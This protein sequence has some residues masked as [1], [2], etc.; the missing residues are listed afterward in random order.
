MPRHFKDLVAYLTDGQ[1]DRLMGAA[2]QLIRKS[3]EF[4]RLMRD[5]EEQSLSQNNLKRARSAHSSITSAVR[6]LL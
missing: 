4:Q 5:I 2:T 1:I 3:P 6:R